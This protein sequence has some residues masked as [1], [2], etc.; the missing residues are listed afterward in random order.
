[1]IFSALHSYSGQ[2]LGRELF[3][4]KYEP[5]LKRRIA[6]IVGMIAVGLA[7]AALFYLP[8]AVRGIG[9]IL[10]SVGQYALILILAPVINRL[11]RMQRTHLY[12]LYTE[13]LTIHL[14]EGKGKLS[15]GEMALWKTFDR[16]EL[17][18]D[19]VKLIPTSILVRPLKLLAEG[20]DRFSAYN[21]ARE[22]ISEAKALRM[23]QRFADR[24]KYL[25]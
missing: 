9:R 13:G 25:P 21:I 4:W 18:D 22:R 16:C 2:P 19:G 10:G 11:W 5:S 15:S 7:V 6:V 20:A 23:T 1:M 17:R 3:R 12:T 24:T 8:H 14:G